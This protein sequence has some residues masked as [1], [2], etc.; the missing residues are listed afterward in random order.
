MKLQTQRSEQ[1]VAILTPEQK[2]KWAGFTL[3]RSV[4]RRYKRCKLVADQDKQIRDACAAAAKTM[5]ATTD[6]KGRG[7]AMKKL[8]KDIEEKILTD[9]QREE[10]KKKPERVPRAKKPK[11]A[12][13]GGAAPVE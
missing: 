5:P 12:K 11:R 3:Y 10:L 8:Y 13:K 2:A 4:M 7:A 1:I 6:R 9:D